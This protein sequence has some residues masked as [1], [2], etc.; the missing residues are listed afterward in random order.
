MSAEV[1]LTSLDRV[2]WQATGFT[3][4]Q[5]IDYYIAVAEVLLPHLSGRPLTLGRFPSGVDGPGFAQTECRGRPAWMATKRLRLRSG[6]IRDFCLVEDLPSLVWVANQGTI[7]LH[8]YLGAGEQGEDAIL[9][10]FDLDPG[11]GAGLLDAARVALRL[12]ALLR[13]LGLASFPKS[14][15]G[16]GLHVFVPLNVPHQYAVVR[17]FCHEVAGPLP[18]GPVRVDCAQNH[19]RRSLIAPYSLR[20]AREP[21]VSAPLV[22]AEVAAAVA[23]GRPE[24]LLFTAERMPARVAQL[25]DPFRPVLELRQRLPG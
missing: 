14:S 12:N 4:R 23:A 1:R 22:W 6:E 17:R 8:P 25:G 10:L 13:E 7:E 18:L 21:T 24:R 9:A 11:R 3:K 2:L 5:L 15:G 16:L 20:A 19:A